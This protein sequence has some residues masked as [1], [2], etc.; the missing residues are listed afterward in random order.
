M[1]VTAIPIL[2]AQT[3]K[4]NDAL[5]SQRTEYYTA[6]KNLLTSGGDSME[7]LMTAYKVM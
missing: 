2:T 3:D 4:K 7:R 6:T 5:V 1:V